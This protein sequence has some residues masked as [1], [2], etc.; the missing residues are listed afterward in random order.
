MKHSVE[1][2][3]AE[4]EEKV[5]KLFLAQTAKNLLIS[6]SA[7]GY[8][9]IFSL[10]VALSGI[11]RL[12]LTQE[13]F[14]KIFSIND[15][16][17]RITSQFNVHATKMITIARSLIDS[18]MVTYITSLCAYQCKPR[19]G[20]ECGQGVGIRQILKFFDQIPQGG[21]RKVNQKRQNSPH[22]RGKNLNK[23]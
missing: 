6:H 14:Q 13:I 11:F 12:L 8:T 16:Q 18:H 23:Q 5:F 4:T 15:L 22:P 21:K 2:A 7:S 20:G 1:N 17:T 19:G 9:T 10:E 3:T